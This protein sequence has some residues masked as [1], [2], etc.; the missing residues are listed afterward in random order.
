MIAGLCLGACDSAQNG[1][2]S[3]EL[4]FFQSKAEDPDKKQTLALSNKVY[5]GSDVCFV[6]SKCLELCH[7][8][9]SLADD[10]KNCRKLKAQ[11]VYQIEKLYGIFLE[12]DPADL[13]NVNVFDLKVFFNVSAEP[14]FQFFKSLDLFSSK[15]FLNWIALNWQVAKVFQEEDDQLLFLRIFLNKLSDSPINSLKEPILKDRTFIESAWLKQND[16][17]LLWLHDYFQKNQC[18]GLKE[19]EL[20]N[21]AIAQ[22]CLAGASF[23][24]DVSTEIIEFKFIKDLVKREGNYTDFKSFCSDLCS[25][26]KGQNYC[27]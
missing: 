24:K 19:R 8:I 13:E 4:K 18:M 11:Q 3:E 7:K 6:D 22:Y 20:D 14:L 21:C 1:F 10:Q 25:S 26:K 27:G 9:Y 12:K 15:I 5:S 23:K 2:S 16:F 17:A